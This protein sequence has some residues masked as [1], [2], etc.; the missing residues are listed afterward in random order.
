MQVLILLLE[1]GVKGKKL[2]ICT[3]TGTRMF[4]NS[5][6]I[7]HTKYIHVEQFN[8]IIKIT[9]ILLHFKQVCTMVRRYNLY[10]MCKN[11]G[12]DLYFIYYI[13]L[14]YAPVVSNFLL[15][16]Y[17]LIQFSPQPLVVFLS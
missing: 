5:N 13:F 11:G 9:V 14:D 7:Y 3:G 4:S 10:V 1:K 8:I 2:Y 6:K 15:N 12:F 16:L 17:Y